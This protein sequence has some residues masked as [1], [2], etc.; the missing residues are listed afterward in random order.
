M[1]ALEVEEQIEASPK[2][3]CRQRNVTGERARRLVV[4]TRHNQ[5]YVI[6][7]QNSSYNDSKYS[8]VTAV[9]K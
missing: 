9:M 8:T 1:P 3:L 5:R 2:E 4:Q 6:Q 7:D